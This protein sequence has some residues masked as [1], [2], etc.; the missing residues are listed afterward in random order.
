MCA[1]GAR[2][3][4]FDLLQLPRLPRVPTP[5]KLRLSFLQLAARSER[6]IGPLTVSAG[7]HADLIDAA[8][9]ILAAGVD[10]VVGTVLV[11]PG[12]ES[13]LTEVKGHLAGCVA[14]KAHYKARSLPQ[15]Y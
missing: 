9:P 13:G 8:A 5:M 12:A 6:V 10:G 14:R 4:S 1:L 15:F 2:A 3:A 7:C 11:D